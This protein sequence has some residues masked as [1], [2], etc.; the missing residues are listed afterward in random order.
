MAVILP[1]EVSIT[2]P[3]LAAGLSGTNGAFKV[4]RPPNRNARKRLTIQINRPDQRSVVTPRKRTRHDWFWE[5][6][7]TARSAADPARAPG[8]AKTAAGRIVG[9]AH[10]KVISRVAASYNAELSAAAA[11]AGVSEALLAAVVAA[12]SAGDPRAVSPAGAQGLAQLMP[13][14]AKRFGVADPFNPAEALRG[15]ADYLS[16]LLNLFDEDVLLALAGYNAGE[17]AV[18]RH[19]G[20][21]PFAE[22][23]D[24]VPIVLG[25]YDIA[26]SLCA[27]RPAGHRDRCDLSPR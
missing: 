23:R 27:A 7:K 1:L 25:Y 19:N 20:V 14:T 24:Y 12:E 4:V 10:H 2:A 17:G 3:S 18:S 26:L 22:T 11:R 15:S 8:L 5:D 9:P 21:P 13:G 16:F 6:A